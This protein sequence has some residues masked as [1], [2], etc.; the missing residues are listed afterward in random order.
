MNFVNLFDDCVG[1]N[2]FL[3]YYLIH[4]LIQNLPLILHLLL[5]NLILLSIMIP[6]LPLHLLPMILILNFLV[7]NLLP[8][9]K[10]YSIT[11]N[12]IL[13]HLIKHLNLQFMYLIVDFI[14][15]VFHTISFFVIVFFLFWSFFQLIFNI[16][17][18]P[19]LTMFLLDP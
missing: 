15:W 17:Y 2:S 13:S 8:H 11:I 7:H 10:L 1:V 6:L 12:T 4:F 19:I 14:F 16:T 3:I 5:K 18:L 9:V